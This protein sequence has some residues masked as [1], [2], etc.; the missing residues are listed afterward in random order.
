MGGRRARD[1]YVAENPAELSEAD[2]AI[3]RGW[4]HRVAGTFYVMK[5]LRRHSLF[6]SDADSTVY[7]VLGLVSSIAEVVP[8][9]PASRRRSCSRGRA[10]S[11]TTA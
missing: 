9:T 3:V 7:A 4:R 6:V 1:A 8:F 10:G 5:H 2:L 11:S